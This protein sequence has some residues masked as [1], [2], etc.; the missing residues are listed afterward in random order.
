MTKATAKELSI[1]AAAILE[2]VR[3]AFLYEFDPISRL[4]RRAP[5]ITGLILSSNCFCIP[6][7]PRRNNL[8]TLARAPGGQMR[9]AA[10]QAMR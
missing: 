8:C 3:R 1:R 7:G 5:C 4:W 2:C 9:G 6:K 10:T